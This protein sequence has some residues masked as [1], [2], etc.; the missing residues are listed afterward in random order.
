MEPV[1]EKNGL[2]GELKYLAVVESDLKLKAHSPAGAVGYW[3]LMKRTATELGLTVTNKTDERKH[4]RKSTTAAANYLRNLYTIYD[5]WLLVI[6]AYNAGPGTV[7]KAIKKAG[8]RNFWR[9][10]AYL[11]AETRGHVKRYIAVYYFFEG[12]GGVTT[13]T[14]EERQRYEKE[15]AVFMEQ[16][17]EQARNVDSTQR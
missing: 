5:D 12:E 14:K 16:I 11:P 1:L 8:S 6:A 4:L 13:L 9:L 7:S 2:P 15:V 17:G 10:Q 3:Q